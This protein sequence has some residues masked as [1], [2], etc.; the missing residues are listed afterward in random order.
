M[1]CSACS[2]PFGPRKIVEH[3][4][5]ACRNMY[6]AIEDLAREVPGDF[7]VIGSAELKSDNDPGL[8]VEGVGCIGLPVN[9]L[10]VKAMIKKS[11]PAP[12]G[13]GEQ[14][15]RDKSVRNTH[16]LDSKSVQL[17][18][19][20]WQQ[21]MAKMTSK[22][23][24][25]LGIAESA[26]VTAELYKLL[27]YPKGGHFKQH[28]DTEKASGMFGSL[29]IVLPSEFFGGDLVVKHNGRSKTFRPS[30]HSK[31]LKLSYAA[32]Y[33]DC[34]HTV[35]PVTK[36]YRI[37]LAYNLLH[38]GG[39]IPCSPPDFFA[40]KKFKAICQ[41]LKEW[42]STGKMDGCD[43]SYVVYLFD[44]KYSRVGI[45]TTGLKAKDALV[46][47][48]LR[49]AIQKGGLKIGIEEVMIDGEAS[50]Y[51]GGFG[52]DDIEWE[53]ENIIAH[54]SFMDLPISEEHVLHEDGLESLIDSEEIEEATGNEGA[55]AERQYSGAGLV[56][57]LLDRVLP[58]MMEQLGL[59]KVV[60]QLSEALVKKSSGEATD[61][62]EDVLLSKEADI[63]QQM[64]QKPNFPPQE[65]VSL[66]KAVMQGAK[67]AKEKGLELTKL[68]LKAPKML[69]AALGQA[70]AI[71]E[72]RTLLSPNLGAIVE[73][74]ISSKAAFDGNFVKAFHSEKGCPKVVHKPIL[75]YVQA[76][77][78]GANPKDLGEVGW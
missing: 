1:D 48:V 28:R 16:Q 51:G 26:K 6:E 65:V 2:K 34:Q 11:K 41:G 23:K 61:D 71:A 35:E 31:D 58:L 54:H 29:I 77:V 25:E 78:N 37:A 69:I 21:F 66:C 7:C 62:I 59:P 10:L 56:L 27:I 12:F 74:L 46:K 17:T 3:T 15:L 64:L 57:V 52:C 36:G 30:L 4:C 49:A 8:N 39:Q 60:K 40:S 63:V 68:I 75:A 18:G 24:L 20:G 67:T 45:S 19:K 38:V 5:V 13:R 33:A 76:T 14:T 55:T 47:K 22:I 42:Q 53:E 50:G 43:V 9:P 44:H 72:M 70:K 73:A 32:F